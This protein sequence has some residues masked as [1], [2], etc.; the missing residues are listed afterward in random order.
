MSFEVAIALHRHV[1]FAQALQVTK[2]HTGR[3][4]DGSFLVPVSSNTGQVA[5]LSLIRYLQFLK[6]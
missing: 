5:I 2:E 4:Q 1:T 6:F 3:E